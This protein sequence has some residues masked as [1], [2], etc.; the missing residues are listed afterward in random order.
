[1]HNLKCGIAAGSDGLTAEHLKYGG[2]RMIEVIVW[3]VNMCVKQGYVPD[4]FGRGVICPIQMKKHVCRNFDDFRPITLVNMLSKDVELL[5]RDKFLHAENINKHRLGFVPGGGYD[6]ALYVVKFICDYCIEHGSS[7]YLSALD[8]SKAYD[9]VNHF[10]LFSCSI[11]ARLPRTVVFLIFCW[12]SKLSG[13]VKWGIYFSV[14]LDI[15]SGCRQRGPWSPW[16]YNLMIND[17]FEWLESSGNG[18]YFRGVYVGYIM[19]ADDIMLMSTSIIKLQEMLHVCIAFGLE[20]GFKFNVKK[21]VCIAYG[22]NV[23]DKLGSLILNNEHLEWVNELVYLEVK[24][25]SG[26]VFGFVLMLMY[27]GVNS[28]LL[29]TKLSLKAKVYLKKF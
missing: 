3:L 11:K 6:K 17:L 24:L 12:Y 5:L 4:D 1:M 2:V 8:I 7:I 10:G 27:R 19:Y 16:L 29:S 13:I 23:K 25:V 20:M 26:K 22:K 18:C 28:L 21:S 9:S 14:P 15:Q